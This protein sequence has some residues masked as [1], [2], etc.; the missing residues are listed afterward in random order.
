MKPCSCPTNCAE[1]NVV[2]TNMIYVWKV[3]RDKNTRTDIQDLPNA[4]GL[5]EH[6]ST[7][8]VQ[9]AGS[10]PLATRPTHHMRE[11]LPTMRFNM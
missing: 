11:N 3:I 9:L 4:Y 5:F 1:Y 7:V 10:G 2:S 6:Y 8:N